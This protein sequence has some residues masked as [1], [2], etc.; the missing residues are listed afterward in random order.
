MALKDEINRETVKL[1]DMPFKKKAAYI[2]EYYR[3]HI[4]AVIAAIVFIC[5]FIRDWRINKRPVYLDVVILNSD[6]AYGED[7]PIEDDYIR[8]AGVDTSAYNISFDAGFLISEN[9]TDQM[10]VA[11]MQK[12]MALFAAGSIDVVLG[13]DSL[14][15]SYGELSAYMD[16]SDVLPE[17]LKQQLIDKGYEVYYSTVYEEDEKG[18]LK[19]VVTFP[20]GFYLDDCEYLD[21][22][23][24]FATQKAAGKRPV[25]AFAS[26]CTNT[27][28][29]VKLLKMLTGL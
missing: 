19:P 15:D 27:D 9:G 3:F 11:N 10:T 8:Y 14:V 4:I 29:A 5:I 1:K 18:V 12:L 28:N 26:C 20:A 13:P 22:L 7:N 17:D 23:S 21:K 24:V 6:I 2:W 16:M 25:F